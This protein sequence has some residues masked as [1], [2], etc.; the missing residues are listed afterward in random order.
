MPLGSSLTSKRMCKK[1]KKRTQDPRRARSTT[2]HSS[3]PSTSAVPDNPSLSSKRS[4]K[5]VILELSDDEIIPPKRKSQDLGGVIRDCI[6]SLV[7]PSSATTGTA[8]QRE[9]AQHMKS[10][11]GSPIC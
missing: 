10:M 7:P 9:F 11:G 2:A 5:R 4:R 8:A 1:K 3:I 6:E